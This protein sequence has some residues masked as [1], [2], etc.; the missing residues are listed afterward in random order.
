MN[1]DIR[2]LNMIPI[3]FVWNENTVHSYGTT[4]SQAPSF[5]EA[6]AEAKSGLATCSA[7]S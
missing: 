2:R 5:P 4:Q 1:C 7:N 3:R 6:R